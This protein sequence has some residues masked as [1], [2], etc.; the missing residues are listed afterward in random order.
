MLKYIIYC[1]KKKIISNIINHL[2]TKNVFCQNILHRL[3]NIIY[4]AFIIKQVNII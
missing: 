1:D 4:T 2:T 3:N